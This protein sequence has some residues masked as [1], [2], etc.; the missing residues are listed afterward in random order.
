[1]LSKPTYWYNNILN[2]V[3]KFMI[4]YKMEIELLKLQNTLYEYIGWFAPKL[5]AFENWIS[6]QWAWVS[7]FHY[8]PRQI[9]L[10][11]L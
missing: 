6:E 1:M 10:A 9:E 3:Q 2:V 11:A 4:F 5:Q 7:G 8:D